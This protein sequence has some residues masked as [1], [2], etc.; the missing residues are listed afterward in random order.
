MTPGLALPMLGGAQ[1]AEWLLILALYVG[2][3]ALV[4]GATWLLGQAF[5][6]FVS[7]S[8][9]QHGRPTSRAELGSSRRP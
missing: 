5:V 8:S 9:V 3:L 4:A 2:I 6:H 1:G 7:A